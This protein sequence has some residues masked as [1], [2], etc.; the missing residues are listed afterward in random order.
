LGG[1]KYETTLGFSVIPGLPTPDADGNADLEFAHGNLLTP[2]PVQNVT[3]SG[4]DSVTKITNPASYSLAINRTT[5]RITGNFTHN[6]DSTVTSF[7]GIVMQQGVNAGAAGFFLTK[8][9]AI[10]DYTGAGGKVALTPQ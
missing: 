5:G 9:P 10:K 3:I 8:T 6:L 7:Q 1:A 2:F 4:V